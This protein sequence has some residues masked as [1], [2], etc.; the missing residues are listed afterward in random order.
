MPPSLFAH[1][2]SELS[3][4]AFLAWLIEWADP[5]HAAEDP[6]LHAVGGG[7][8]AEL[9]RKAERPLQDLG[10]VTSVKV[11]RQ[12]LHID[13]L[14][15]VNGTRALILEDKVHAGQHGNQLPR[16]R[17]AIAKDKRSFADGIHG[18]YLKTGVQ[19]DH[20]SVRDHGYG[21]FGRGHLL[22]LLRAGLTSGVT[23]DTYVDF[24][25]HLDRLDRE[26]N[27][28]RTSAPAEW[29]VPPGR[30]HAMAR[31][32]MDLFNDLCVRPP[33]ARWDYTS[34]PAGGYYVVWLAD[35]Q[36]GDGVKLY[37]QA[38]SL[39]ELQVR[40]RTDAKDTPTRIAQRDY[41]MPR[42]L[43]AAPEPF[44]LTPPDQ[45]RPGGTMSIAHHRARWLALNPDGGVSAPD[46]AAKIAALHEWLH[47][48]SLPLAN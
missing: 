43:S 17:D 39:G 41:W 44:A 31:A 12:Y 47:T 42:V 20:V 29:T 8:L 3:Q 28:W 15:V 14:V 11:E 21:Y 4:D 27:E 33:G 19:T 7:F 22:Q 18:V 16:Y 40:V 2:S 5:K 25:G 32:W 36:V 24:T 37:V 23:N 1:A 34:N 35:R 10:P 46:T 38:S 13:L 26:F 30:K 6:L 48:M 9:F 45:V